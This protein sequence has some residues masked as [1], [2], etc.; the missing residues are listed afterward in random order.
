KMGQITAQVPRVVS[1]IDRHAVNDAIGIVKGNVEGRASDEGGKPRHGFGAALFVE[2]QEKPRQHA[3]LKRV[4]NFQRM[5]RFFKSSPALGE[6]AA[7]ILERL[8]PLLV[9]QSARP[10]PLDAQRRLTPA[11][12]DPPL[13]VRDAQAHSGARNRGYSS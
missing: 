7:E 1:L 12:G 6:L 4:A 8:V 9:R 11:V 10:D 13:C 3:S 5:T 2:G